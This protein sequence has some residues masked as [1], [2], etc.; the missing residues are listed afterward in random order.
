MKS[1]YTLC[2]ALVLGLALAQT[3]TTS[4]PTAGPSGPD[5]PGIRGGSG[6]GENKHHFLKFGGQLLVLGLVLYGVYKCGYRRG[7][8]MALTGASTAQSSYFQLPAACPCA[9]QQVHS[10]STTATASPIQT[11]PAGTVVL[12]GTPVV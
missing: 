1:T 9:R 6:R 4:N 2:F 10:A 11:Y 7:R 3:S 5:V 12:T 8:R